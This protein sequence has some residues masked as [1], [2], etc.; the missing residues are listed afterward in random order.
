MNLLPEEL[1]D[2]VAR[3]LER[4]R[5]QLNQVVTEDGNT[6]DNL[7]T[8]NNFRFFSVAD[9]ENSPLTIRRAFL[10]RNDQFHRETER[11]QYFVGQWRMSRDVLDYLAGQMI[12]ILPAVRAEFA[13]FNVVNDPAD[14]TQQHGR[15]RR[16]GAFMNLTRSFQGFFGCAANIL[17]VIVDYEEVF[18]FLVRRIGDPNHPFQPKRFTS[19]IRHTELLAGV[20]ELLLRGNLGRFTP[21]P[22]LRSALE[23][24]ISRSLSRTLID[25]NYNG[26]YRG[27][28]VEA[29]RGFQMSD[30]LDAADQ[31]RYPFLISTD[32]VRRMYTWGSISTHRA[33]TMRHSEIWYLLVVI[34]QIPHQGILDIPDNQL[35][36]AWDNILDTLAARGKITILP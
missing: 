34:Q 3:A 30:I 10:L 18:D 28:T 5:E 25:P 22:L 21:P 11:I 19:D 9:F 31:H 1:N 8:Q 35:S 36:Q 4:A 14:Q 24:I 7:L 15:Q 23:A 17:D 33:W 27:H 26:R 13:S 12:D 32:A 20:K 29:Q 2:N 6:L 16:I